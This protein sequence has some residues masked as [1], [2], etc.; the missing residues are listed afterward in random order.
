MATW[1]KRKADLAGRTLI[2]TE[3]I[4]TGT[5]IYPEGTR[6]TVDGTQPN[7]KLRLV[8]PRC[9]HCGVRP[10][11]Y[12]PYRAGTPAK[13]FRLATDAPEHVDVPF[14]FPEED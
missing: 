6:W 9:V 13:G 11:V 12:F 10:F 14:E 2:A 8:A 4:R 1:P 5:A 7:G 3:E